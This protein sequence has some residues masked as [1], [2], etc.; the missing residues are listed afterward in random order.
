MTVVHHMF[1]IHF[2]A[3]ASMYH[4]ILVLSLIVFLCQTWVPH[5]MQHAPQGVTDTHPRKTC[6]LTDSAPVWTPQ[7]TKNIRK[8]TWGYTAG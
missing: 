6:I 4:R 5:M 3:N 8:C 2:T 7:Y 1:T